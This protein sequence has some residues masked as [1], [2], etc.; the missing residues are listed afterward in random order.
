LS[1]QPDYVA[2]NRVKQ[3]TAFLHPEQMDMTALDVKKLETGA[4]E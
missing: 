1:R 3:P 4:V 2:E